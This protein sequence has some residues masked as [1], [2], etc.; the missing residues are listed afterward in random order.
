MAPIVNAVSA[1]QT[2]LRWVTE[3]CGPMEWG[4]GRELIS[5]CVCLFRRIY[6]NT[7]SVH[8][9]TP[10]LIKLVEEEVEVSLAHIERSL[11]RINC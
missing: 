2:P 1:G 10:S 9:W 3:I 5:Y 4:M 8:D 6:S 11:R 7:V